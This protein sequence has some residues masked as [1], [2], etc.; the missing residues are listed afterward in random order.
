MRRTAQ[1]LILFFILFFLAP[2][3]LPD[4][5]ESK[6]EKEFNFPSGVLFEE[7]NNLNSFSKW[8]P[9]TY[10]DENAVREYYSPYRGQGAGYKWD[11]NSESG[12]LTISKV[13]DLESLEYN[14]ELEDL[15]KSIKMNVDFVNDKSDKTK[16][17]W[18][19][20]GEKLNYFTRYFNFFNSRKI[21]N[22]LEEGLDNL[23]EKL[24]STALSSV[25]AKSLEPGM[26]GRELFEG[27]EVLS[28]TSQTA[29]EEK[30]IFKEAE[31]SFDKITKYLT[32][33]ADLTPE[34]LGKPITYF[35]S[36][37]SE[38]AEFYSG[39]PVRET[40][41]IPSGMELKTISPTET[42]I[43]THKGSYETIGE[44]V[45]KIKTYAREKGLKLA[46][47][48][49]QEFLNIPEESEDTEELLTKVYIPISNN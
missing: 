9:W 20:S 37:D 14:L 44:T 2:I 40:V 7:F 21:E 36:R 3:F 48:Y 34:E 23:E 18:N 15:G 47:S 32:R 17:I 31:K 41:R 27:L 45:E 12:N 22:K 29:L 19:V 25:Q 30:V 26:V 39:I 43:C 46:D 24:N 33:E 38:T 10:E 8:D 6:A 35:I 16:V 1:F 13:K 5:I 28:V 49:W 42:L 11:S 4:S